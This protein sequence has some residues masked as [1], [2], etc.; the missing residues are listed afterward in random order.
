VFDMLIGLT[1]IV[2]ILVLFLRKMRR[3]ILQNTHAALSSV[4]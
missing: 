4:K 3:N 1:S 2:A